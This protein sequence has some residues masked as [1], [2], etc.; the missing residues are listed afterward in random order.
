MRHAFTRHAIF[1]TAALLAAPVTAQDLPAFYAVTG[2][3]A[4]DVLNIRAAPDS[5]ADLLGTLAPDAIDIQVSA[6]NDAGTWGRITTGEGVGWVS[7][8]FLAPEENGSLP[9]VAGL[10]CFG[11]EPFWTYEVRQGESASWSTPDDP[12]DLLQAG[13][14]ETASGRS[15]PFSSVAGADQLQAVL[16]ASPESQCS[17]GMSDRLYGLAATLVLTGRISRTLG[18]CCELMR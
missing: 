16:V 17:D 10:R 13:P 2:V 9:Q 11:T 1:L 15:W 7:M 18:G 4:D 14:F 12:E 8:S 6:L 5:G 3:A